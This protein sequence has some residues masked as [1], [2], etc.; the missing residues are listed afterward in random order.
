M[1]SARRFWKRPAVR[2]Y[3]HKGLIWRASS[4]TEVGAIEL[5]V[6]LLYVGIIAVIGDR[7]AEE[8]TGEALL[9]FCVTFVLSWRLWSDLTMVMSW[10]E[11]DDVVQRVC[12][13]VF[14]ACEWG[15]FGRCKMGLMETIGLVGFTTNIENAFSGS[16]Y[17]ELIAFYLAERLFYALYFVLIAFL[18]PMIRGVLV[19]LVIMIM[20]SS[21]FWIG[22]IHVAYPNQLALIWIAIVWDMFA[23]SIIVAIVGASEHLQ[24]TWM[25]PVAKHMQFYPALNIEHRAERMNAFVTLVIGYSVVAL[26]Y[27]SDAPAGINAF[28]G[29]AVL[30]LI[31]AFSFCLI[32]FE[33]DSTNLYVHAIRRHKFTCKSVSLYRQSC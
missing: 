33:V 5:F 14:V 30:G 31:I 26:L 28:Y 8:P 16:T 9:G 6:D 12:V 15:V 11:A 19:A 29:K 13:L 25:A 2:Q 21:A 20:I 27:Q 18:I 3:F 24:D 10:I 17:T 1:G 4:H 23:T 22:S 7:A 32:Y